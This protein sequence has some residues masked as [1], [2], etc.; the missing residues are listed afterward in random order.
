MGGADYDNED[1]FISSGRQL[2]A[3]PGLML[4][5]GILVDNQLILGASGWAILFFSEEVRSNDTKELQASMG[6]RTA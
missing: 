5:P 1:I 3:H 2:T 6:R 4:G